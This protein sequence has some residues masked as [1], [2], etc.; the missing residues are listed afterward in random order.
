M[1]DVTIPRNQSTLTTA[2]A[3]SVSTALVDDG[4][5]LGSDF[6]LPDDI[7]FS[8]GGDM[9]GD[10]NELQGVEEDASRVEGAGLAALTSVF[11]CDHI[12]RKKMNNKD[13]W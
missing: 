13:G 7:S 1:S 4:E 11:D 10:E 5:S 9:G 12:K 8:G 2:A 6:D 3:A